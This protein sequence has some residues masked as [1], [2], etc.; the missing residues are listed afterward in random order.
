MLTSL[1]IRNVVLIDRLDLNFKDGLSVLTGETGAGKSI[2]LDALGLATGVRAEGGLVR[3]GAERASVTASFEIPPEHASIEMLDEHGIDP[4]EVLVLRRVVS[5]DGRSR[6][7]INDQPASVGLLRRVGATLVEI[8]GQFE[9]HGLMNPATHLPLLDAYGGLTLQRRETTDSYNAWRAAADALEHAKREAEQAAEDEDYLRH[10]VT[11]LEEI[12]PQPGEEATLAEQRR[13]LMHAEQLADGLKAA[14]SEIT[15]KADVAGALHGAL[16]RLERLT[17]KA[18]DKLDGAIAAIDRCMA[19]FDEVRSQLQDAANEIDL[20]GSHLSNTEERLFALRELARK[21][22]TSVDGLPALKQEM[23]DRMALIDNTAETLTRLE[24]EAKAARTAYLK[25]AEALSAE[26]ASAAE[27]LDATV[28]AELPPLRLGGATFE[29]VIQ[30]RE[31]P[32]WT[33][34]GVDRADFQVAT[35]PG[36]PKGPIA[37]FASG[38][39]LSRFMLALK[40]ALAE[41]GSLRTLIFDE[42]D[43]GVGGATAD[44]VGERLERL[45]DKM[46]VFVV[47]H[48]PQV[49]ARG[50]DHLRVRKSDDTD[51]AITMVEPLDGPQR[52][53]EIARML[54]GAKVTDE[55]RAAADRLIDGVA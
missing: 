13:V 20:D 31:E 46:Q 14:R 45:A 44:A 2:L 30:R 15:R 54:S 17:E 49:A 47:T 40:V 24:G 35:N 53:E 52:K 34:D 10:A 48:S 42:V 6:A 4:E 8:Q 51:R 43:S 26:R 23:S 39:E 50:R 55:A 25:R 1:G 28:V 3:H 11:E 19:E 29:T 9:Q 36:E 33:A 18:G 5:L 38:G 32:D 37:K 7:Y 12:D 22:R 41:S 16:R 27:R 21:Y